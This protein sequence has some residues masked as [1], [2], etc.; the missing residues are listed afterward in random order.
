MNM[1][2]W[3]TI[4]LGIARSLIFAIAILIWVAGAGAQRQ[5]EASYAT[6]ESWRSE[7]IH[8]F[9]RSGEPIVGQLRS[10]VNRLTSELGR[11][12]VSRSTTEEDYY[13]ALL[14]D[15]YTHL[16]NWKEA[17]PIVRRLAARTM[18][19]KQAEQTYQKLAGIY[20]MQRRWLLACNY[21]G[22]WVGINYLHRVFPMLFLSLGWLALWRLD[23]GD[24][25]STNFSGTHRRRLLLLAFTPLIFSIVT[26]GLMRINSYLIAGNTGEALVSIHVHRLCILMYEIEWMLLVLIVVHLVRKFGWLSQITDE[27]ST[28]QETILPD[29]QSSER[30]RISKVGLFALVTLLGCA[31]TVFSKS[32]DYL[33]VVT[34][35]ETY[36]VFAQWRHR[37]DLLQITELIFIAVISPIVQELYF[38]GIVYA[39]ARNCMNIGF[40]LV[41]SSVIFAGVHLDNDHFAALFLAGVL[42]ALQ[43]EVAK[44]LLPSI[45]THS[46][47]NFI[48]YV[49]RFR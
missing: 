3:P 48:S 26:D 2:G 31:L 35:R 27:H 21:Y 44:S 43:Y 5:P 6:M 40:G 36:Q 22:R 11:S 9:D 10:F 33:G 28:L 49:S 16:G 1:E 47:V 20:A 12:S 8:C 4:K 13:Q 18:S 17:E 24:L 23:K 45:L 14:A 46:A 42:L 34:S 37:P 32:G 41:F 30:R 39:Y 15:A 29:G 19:W 38:R 25:S 7:Y